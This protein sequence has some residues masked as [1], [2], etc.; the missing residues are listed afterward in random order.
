MTT[1]PNNGC[2]IARAFPY[3]PPHRQLLLEGSYDHRQT[4]YHRQAAHHRQAHAA[5]SPI[6]PARPPPPEDRYDEKMTSAKHLGL[7]GSFHH[8]I[9][10]L[11]NPETTIVGTE[12]YLVA[13]PARNMAGS[14][15]PTC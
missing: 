3:N 2:K 7:T 9:H 10:H 15:Y 11:G 12:R 1:R 8:L 6:P 14:R 5:R 4:A 13:A